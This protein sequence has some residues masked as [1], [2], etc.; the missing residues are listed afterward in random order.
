MR[1]FT[2]LM[3]SNKRLCQLRSGIKRFQQLESCLQQ[4]LPV[5]LVAYVSLLSYENGILLIQVDNSNWA[6][7]VRFFLPQLSR[8]LKKSYLFKGLE[9]VKIK[10][11]PRFCP[12]ASYKSAKPKALSPLAKQCLLET[13]ELIQD[14]PLKAALRKLA[15]HGSEPQ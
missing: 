1:N 14:A 4:A 15:K 8:D 12:P 10:T 3:T 2:D 13:A 7:K 11:K 9:K 5:S 6:G